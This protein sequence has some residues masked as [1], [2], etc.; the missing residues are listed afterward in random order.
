MQHQRPL[1]GLET[2]AFKGFSLPPQA[3]SSK[4]KAVQGQPENTGNM[5]EFSINE[6]RII[7]LIATSGTIARVDLARKSG[8]TGAS[9]TRI[10][11]ALADLELLEETPDK[12]GAL[13]QPKRMLS[14]KPNSYS[15]PALH[16]P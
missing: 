8:L 10:I 1:A 9:V 16:S 5:R 13:G 11:A 3:T 12:M 6:R 7:E 14:I 4:A 2:L 15:R